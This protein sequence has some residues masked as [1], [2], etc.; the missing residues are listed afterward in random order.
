[1]AKRR[2]P[3]RNGVD[4]LEAAI[5]ETSTERKGRGKRETVAAAPSVWL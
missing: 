4:D 1:M 5:E 2:R 3:N